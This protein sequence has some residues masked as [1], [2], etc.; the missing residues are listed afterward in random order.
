MH[1]LMCR[2]QRSTS[3]L[4]LYFETRSLADL[5]LISLARLASQGWGG[6]GLSAYLASGAE[7]TSTHHHVCLFLCG[8]WE[9]SSGIHADTALYQLRYLP[10]AVMD[11]ALPKGTQPCSNK[12][13]CRKMGGLQVAE[14]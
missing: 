9:S 5:E 12:T 11:K 10:I 8:F 14:L 2:I 3:A 7:I 4:F 6:G 13:L 1:A